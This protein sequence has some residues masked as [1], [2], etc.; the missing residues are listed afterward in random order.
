MKL[1]VNYKL[2]HIGNMYYVVPIHRT[3]NKCVI[4]LNT[5]SAFLWQIFQEEQNDI[6][7]VVDDYMKRFNVSEKIAKCDVHAFIDACSV[8][9]L[10]ES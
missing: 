1:S 2:N 5:Y 10:W 7:Y 3:T 8:N 6:D 9:Q 4:E